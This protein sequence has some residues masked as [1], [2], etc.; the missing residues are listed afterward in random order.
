VAEKIVVQGLGDE[1]VSLHTRS[2]DIPLLAFRSPGSKNSMTFGVFPD[3]V[4]IFKLDS[5]QGECSAVFQIA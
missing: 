3:G 2:G 5:P 1:H 4:P